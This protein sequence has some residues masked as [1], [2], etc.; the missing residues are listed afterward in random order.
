[1]E[2][3]GLHCNVYRLADGTDFSNQGITSHVTEVVLTGP[4]V[5][6]IFAPDE[7]CPE[8]VL[9]MRHGTLVARPAAARP[10]GHAG[11]MFG[12]NF[13]YSSDGRFPTPHQAIPVHDRSE[14]FPGLPLE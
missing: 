7:R 3:R 14:P 4:G 13:I 9:E 5:P 8:L 11:W 2:R 12:G 10:P 6:R 1:M